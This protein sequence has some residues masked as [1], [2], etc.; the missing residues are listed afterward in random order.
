MGAIDSVGD[1]EGLGLGLHALKL[2][3]LVR[4]D[5]LDAVEATEKIEMPPGSAKLAVRRRLQADLRLFPDDIFNFPI[6]D[7]AELFGV[8]LARPALGA[9]ALADLSVNHYHCARREC[10]ERAR[11]YRLF[12]LQQPSI[13]FVSN[14][15]FMTRRKGPLQRVWIVP[16]SACF[17]RLLMSASDAVDGSHHRHRDVPNRGAVGRGRDIHRRRYRHFLVFPGHGDNITTAPTAGHTR[18]SFHSRR[19]LS[20][21][22]RPIQKRPNSPLAAS[23]STKLSWFRRRPPR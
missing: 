3:A 6:L 8:D 19:N 20:G 2:D 15:P 21:P 5:D 14:R 1:L 22:L 23:L 13:I 17:E 16:I 18:S 12:G 9:G 10:A 11:S 4:L 7:L